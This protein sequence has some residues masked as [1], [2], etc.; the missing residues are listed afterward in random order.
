[1]TYPIEKLKI[2][3]TKDIPPLSQ[4]KCQR[5]GHI[6][7]LR[8]P[9]PKQCPKCNSPYWNKSRRKDKK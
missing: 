5:C 6:W 3:E 1:M 2:I 8:K 4:V 9:N 7:I